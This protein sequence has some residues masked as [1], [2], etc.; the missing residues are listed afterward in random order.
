MIVAALGGLLTMAFHPTAEGLLVAA[1]PSLARRGNQAVH[2]LGIVSVLA[3]LHG[4]IGLTNA[5]FGHRPGL[6]R[7]N[8]IAAG[9]AAAFASLAAIAS[10]F[11]ASSLLASGDRDSAAWRANAATNQASAALFVVAFAV[12]VV[13]SSWFGRGRL[14][15]WLSAF[16]LGS[17]VLLLAA[18]LLGHLRLGV[19]GFGVVVVAQ[20]VWMFG[21]AR[22]LW[23]GAL[24]S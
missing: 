20:S 16:G 5:L 7:T 24:R 6:V 22:V 18:L 10:G 1:D 8:L 3:M 2:L 15:R 17:S 23:R 4:T 14:P 12:T 13:V 19:H 11:V 21:T 9:A